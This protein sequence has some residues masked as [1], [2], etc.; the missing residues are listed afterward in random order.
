MNI[1][2]GFAIGQLGE[3]G[4]KWLRVCGRLRFA[5]DE[6]FWD[7][8]CLEF[9]DGAFGWLESEDGQTFITLKKKLLTPVPPWEQIYAGQ[10]LSV[11]NAPFFVTEKTSAVITAWEGQ[12]PF[13]VQS[14]TRVRFAD[15]NMSGQS[16]SLEWSDGGIEFGLGQEVQSGDLNFSMPSI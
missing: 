1:P 7:E 14:G 13:P 16:A 3:W 6:S 5:D 9:S 12:L 15:G 2:R 8:W 10:M 11:N 4:S